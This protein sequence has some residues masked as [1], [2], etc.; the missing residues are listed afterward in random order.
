MRLLIFELQVVIAFPSPV[1]ILNFGAAGT[2]RRFFFHTRKA[3]FIIIRFCFG[4]ISIVI[5][6]DT[7]AWSTKNPG[8]LDFIWITCDLNRIPKHFV[9]VK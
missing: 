1:L 7:V 2:S 5:F 4:D 9:T 3:G 8:K 6:F